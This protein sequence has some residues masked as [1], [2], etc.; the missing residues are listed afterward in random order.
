[1]DQQNGD[2]LLQ[3]RLELCNVQ[4]I[5]ECLNNLGPK[6]TQENIRQAF[7]VIDEIESRLSEIVV[8]SEDDED[9]A[10]VQ[11]VLDEI[12]SL[13]KDIRDTHELD[14]RA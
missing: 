11:A 7:H 13:I 1:M 6:V 8:R 12:F 9:R 5:H 4:A 3:A 10:S 2:D 14:P